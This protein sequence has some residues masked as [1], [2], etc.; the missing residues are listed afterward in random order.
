MLLLF[1]KR[2][3]PLAS[4]LSLLAVGH[5]RK[6]SNPMK[7]IRLFACMTTSVAVFSLLP[8]HS[9]GQPPSGYSAAV[10]PALDV[11]LGE[12]GL[13][14]G[15]IVDAEGH[16]KADAVLTLC[17]QDREVACT[18]TDHVGRF[19]VTGLVP[20]AYQIQSPGIQSQIRAWSAPIAPPTASRHALPHGRFHGKSAI[21]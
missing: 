18:T 19:E 1:E 2:N 8:D 21:S 17:Q 10:S 5:D 20:G 9:L 6:G 15:Q 3:R 7:H 14:S 16:A 4:R 13:L 11:V 12:D